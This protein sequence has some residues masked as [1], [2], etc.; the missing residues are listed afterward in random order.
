MSI[1]K[2]VS[3][4]Q[5]IAEQSV[6]INNHVKRCDVCSFF[7][8]ISTI[9]AAEIL[10]DKITKSNTKEGITQLMVEKWNIKFLLNHYRLL[11]LKV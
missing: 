1:C 10:L 3:E 2:D 4:I 9:A 5:I 8:K 6:P 11:T 7:R